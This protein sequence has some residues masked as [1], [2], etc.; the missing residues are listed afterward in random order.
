M[1]QLERGEARIM[2]DPGSA[3]IT[4]VLLPQR[5]RRGR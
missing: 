3:S 2:F 4:I 5:E 1:G